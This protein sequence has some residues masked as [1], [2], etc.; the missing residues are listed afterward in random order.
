MLLMK[1]SLLDRLDHEALIQND[2]AWFSEFLYGG[3]CYSKKH[4]R[5]IRLTLECAT[6]ATVS[7][8]HES[9]VSMLFEVYGKID[10]A[11]ML[12]SNLILPFS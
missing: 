3:R 10:A 4:Q 6:Y 9:N 12:S 7:V 2:A 8:K 1:D 11:T 5:K